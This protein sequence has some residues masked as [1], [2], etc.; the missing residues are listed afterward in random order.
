[1]KRNIIG[2]AFTLASLMMAGHA[3]AED[4][5]VHFV[6]EIVDST[7][8]VTSD[9]ADQTVPLGKVNKTAFSGVGSVASPQEFSIKLINCPATYTKAAVR[10]DG[11][12]APGGD[13]DLKVGT[14]ITAAA[15]GD[16]TGTGPAIV[17]EGV[18]IRIFN[19]ASNSQV[20]LYS[21]SDYTPIDAAG[22]AEM[23]FIARYI[24]TSANVTPGTANADSQFTIEYQK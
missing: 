3:L 19:R 12:E 17:A 4:G 21:D 10:F 24:A 6:G 20:K 13:G 22:T 2:G 7:C 5:V 14:P 8:E 23:K 11:T 1:M 16:Y 18:G 9:T 15:P